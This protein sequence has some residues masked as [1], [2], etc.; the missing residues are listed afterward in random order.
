[1]SSLLLFH[2][3]GAMLCH[4]FCCV[5]SAATVFVSVDHVVVG[6]AVESWMCGDVLL[7]VAFVALSMLKLECCCIVVEGAMLS[8]ASK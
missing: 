1:M 7:D 8:I 2:R 5:V 3:C 4:G 6:P